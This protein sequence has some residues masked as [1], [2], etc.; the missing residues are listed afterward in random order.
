MPAAEQLSENIP[1][2]LAGFDAKAVIAVDPHL[3]HSSG[4]KIEP[5]LDQHGEIILIRRGGAAL[6]WITSGDN[7]GEFLLG[8]ARRVKIAQPVGGS[9][10][11]PV[12]IIRV[13][14][15]SPLWA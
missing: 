14:E 2:S 13:D 11:V 10:E 6:V 9:V 5:R 4:R 7:A 1:G 12:D 15:V 3:P 8:I